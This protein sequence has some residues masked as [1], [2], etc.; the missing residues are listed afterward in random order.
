MEDRFDGAEE[1]PRWSPGLRFSAPNRDGEA[2]SRLC[3]YNRGEFEAKGEES[4]GEEF[5]VSI[6]FLVKVSPFWRRH[7]RQ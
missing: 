2:G 6:G 3:Q 7:G 5:S 1:L 4:K